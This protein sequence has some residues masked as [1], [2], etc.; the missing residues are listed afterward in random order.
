M[1]IS[2]KQ[3]EILISLVHTAGREILKIYNNKIIKNYKKD[4]TP[5]TNADLKAVS[6]THL[7]LPT[8]CSV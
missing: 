6:Y 2:E 7:T 4:N 1:K 3:S 8:I 5:V